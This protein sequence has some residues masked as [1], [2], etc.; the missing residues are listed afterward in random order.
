[1]KNDSRQNMRGSNAE[2]RC[3]VGVISKCGN[4]K[5]K[6]RGNNWGEGKAKVWEKI[7]DV[8]INEESDVAVFF[9]N[10][11][12]NLGLNY[13]FNFRQNYHFRRYSG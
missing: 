10:Q 2:N 1:M 6:R 9:Q 11:K 8:E 7:V 4:T 5:R 3:R 13:Y 12:V